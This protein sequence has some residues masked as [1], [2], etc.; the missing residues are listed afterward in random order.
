MKDLRI[1]MRDRKRIALVAHD[2]RKETLLE[3]V[4]FNSGS[5]SRHLLYATGTTGRLIEER[6]GLPV[7]RL[8]SGPL[9]GDQQIG[10][11]IAE[12]KLDFLFFFWDPLMTQPHDPDVKAL[13]RLAVV[14]NIPVAMNR[15]SADFM[16]SSHL[17]RDEYDRLVPDY[18]NYRQRH[19]E[20]N[21]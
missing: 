21:S 17:M 5:L 19:I 15:S 13:L 8:E 11:M 6:T 4:E 9:G 16:I 14:W 1:T 18:H 10:A 12:G 7:Q 20:S 2:H 3:W